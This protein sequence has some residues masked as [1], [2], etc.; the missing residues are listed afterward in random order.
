[1]CLKARVSPIQEA[2]QDNIQIQGAQPNMKLK[3]DSYMPRKLKIKFKDCEFPQSSKSETAV[4]LN[5]ST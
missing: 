2:V 3:N 4:L 5:T 1:M